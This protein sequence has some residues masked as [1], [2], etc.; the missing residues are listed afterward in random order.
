MNKFTWLSKFGNP[1]IAYNHITD[2][3]KNVMVLASSVIPRMPNYSQIRTINIAS[4][5]SELSIKILNLKI[6]LQ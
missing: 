3:R 4:K 1:E 6:N 2:V 5:C